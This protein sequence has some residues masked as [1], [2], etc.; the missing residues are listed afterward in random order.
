MDYM[1]ETKEMSLEL[2]KA[3]KTGQIS[4]KQAAE[5]ANKMRNEIMEFARIR[6]SDL[7]RAKAK[8][9]KAKGVVC[10]FLILQNYRKL[11]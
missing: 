2:S 1:H 4:A 3:Y 11:I 10:V 7:G 9:M 6:S 5:A 8:S